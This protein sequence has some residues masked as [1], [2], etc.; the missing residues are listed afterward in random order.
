VRKA[1]KLLSVAVAVVAVA[2]SVGL[3][4]FGSAVTARQALSARTGDGIVVLTGGHQRLAQASRLLVDGYAR[5]LLISGVNRL[6]SRDDM[7]RLGLVPTHL[8]DCCVDIGHEALDTVGNADEA[9]NW[10]DI[11]KFSRLVI[12]TSDYHMPRSLAEFSRAMPGMEL[13]PHAVVTPS[14]LMGEWWQH[15]LFARRV[16]IEYVKFWPAAVRLAL[17]RVTGRFEDKVLARSAASS[18]VATFA[19][20]AASPRPGPARERDLATRL[21]RSPDVSSDRSPLRSLGDAPKFR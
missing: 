4:V 11:W 10:A 17:A 14:T 5:R 21:D 20:D 15:P 3:S 8:F 1:V 12:V 6:T 9:R 13:A 2:A 19:P 18:P 16:V 7:R